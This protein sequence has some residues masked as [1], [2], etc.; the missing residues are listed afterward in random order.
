M[1]NKHVGYLVIGIAVLIGFIIYSFN[2]ALVDIVSVSCSHGDS[3]PMWGN[4]EFQ[5]N[6]SL[7]MMGFVIAVGL[8][9]VLF[10]D[11]GTLR[12]RKKKVF[13]PEG[14]K[15]DENVIF[16]LIAKSDGSI[17]QSELVKEAGLSKVKVTR[18][19]DKL[20]GKGLLERKRRGM[21]NV[22]ILKF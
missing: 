2:T 11:K 16:E 19:L 1:E 8:Y 7:A 10:A 3:C 17:L 12:I 18:I 20:E 9:L 22:V 6:V 5:T 13:S 14:L 21:T 4:I 15:G